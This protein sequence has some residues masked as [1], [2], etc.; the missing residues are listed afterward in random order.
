[1]Q[2]K[3][4]PDG[5]IFYGSNA[6]GGWQPQIVRVTDNFLALRVRN[7]GAQGQVGALTH[8]VLAPRKRTAGRVNVNTVQS[9][10]AT[11]RGNHEYFSTLLGLP[12]VV[13]AA[14]SVIPTNGTNFLAGPIPPADDI[15]LRSVAP[16]SFAWT[17][18]ERRPPLFNPPAFY[19]DSRTPPSRNR[20]LD[21]LNPDTDLLVPNT[22]L[23]NNVEHTIGAFRLNGLMMAGR[24]EHA[25]GRYY[26]S[27]GGLTNDAN[28][29]DYEYDFSR[30]DVPQLTGPGVDGVENSAVYPLSNESLPLRRFDDIQRRIGTMGNLITVR[31]DVFEIIMT[32]EAGYGIDQ[33]KDGFINYRDRNEF[34]TTAATKATATYERRAPSDQSDSGE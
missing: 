29:F 24:T 16:S 32:V 10:V 34:V 2:Y 9:R 8:V 21:A 15:A 3:A 1:M 25:D 28:A 19:E 27:V 4:G 30:A 13:D 31:S 5:Y 7:L 17:P 20:Y 14:K 33:N 26:E 22:G 12:G 6:A 23:A 11:V 18:P